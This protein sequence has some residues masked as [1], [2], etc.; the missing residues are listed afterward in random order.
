MKPFSA[1]VNWL[2]IG[3]NVAV[4]IGL[5]LVVLELNQNAELARIGL[6]NDGNATENQLFEALMD[7]VPRNIIAKSLECPEKLDLPDYVVLDSYLYT[8]MNL[9]Y[10]NYELAKEGFFEE[11]DWKSEVDNYAQWYLSSEFGKAYWENIGRNYFDEEFSAYVD[12]VIAQPGV[13]MKAAW[14]KVA[15]GLPSRKGAAVDVITICQLP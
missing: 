6:I 11:S 4:I 1:A 9:V 5:V 2:S 10:R 13:D 8:G 12:S 3:T 7:D 15:A 14:T